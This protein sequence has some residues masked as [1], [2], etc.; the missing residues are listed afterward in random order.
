MG[1]DAVMIH[2]DQCDMT[3]TMAH[4]KACGNLCNRGGLADAGRTDQRHCAAMGQQVV[5]HDGQ[6]ILKDGNGLLPA[7][8]LIVDGVDAVGYA[9]G[10]N[11]VD[12]HGIEMFNNRGTHRLTPPDLIPTELGQRH[13]QHA[14]QCAYLCAHLQQR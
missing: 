3:A 8:G 10:N 4:G 13:L 12:L 7:R 5:V 11:R 2:A 6:H 1:P 14:A 9:V